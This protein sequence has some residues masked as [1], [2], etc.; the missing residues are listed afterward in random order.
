MQQHC[1]RLG[2]AISLVLAPISLPHASALEPPEKPK[3]VLIVVFDQMRP[4]YAERFDMRNLLSLQKTGVHFPNGYLGHL[5]AQTVVSHNVMV[6]GLYPKRQGWVDEGYRDRLNLLGKGTNAIWE[7]G[8]LTA[9]QFGILIRHAGYPKLVDYLHKARPGSKFIVVGEKSHPVDSIAAPN[10]DISVRHSERSSDTSPATG[11]ANLGGSWRG[12][13]GINV[14]RY[15]S[16]PRCGR[17]YINSDKAND[18]DTRKASPSWLYPLEGNR[19]VAG[20]DPGHLGGDAWSADAAMTMMEREDWGGMLVTLGGI[21]KAGH[22][23][24]AYRDNNSA[25]GSIDE[26]SRVPFAAKFADE[27][28]GRMLRQLERLGQL[29]ETLIVITADHGATSAKHF[30]GSDERGAGYYNWYF[31]T[32]DYDKP[33]AALGPL[34]A[35]GNLQFSVQSTSISA[36]LK[37]DSPLQKKAAARIMRGLPGVAAT[38]WRDG[39]RFQL[40]AAPG[41]GTAAKLGERELRWW[42]QH[43][44]ELLDS[45]AADSGPDVIGLLAEDVSYGA[46]G[47]H[48]SAK[49]SDQ[50]IPMVIWARNIQPGKPD[51]GF[52]SIDILPTVLDAMGIPQTYPGDGKAWKLRFRQEPDAPGERLETGKS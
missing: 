37:E 25:P 40:D 43:G 48:G 4:E 28:L 20:N 17:F 49:E 12:P 38:Y 7:T 50:R 34:V 22:M 51:Y 18:H 47:D 46:Y 33:A 14:P 44:Q 26:Q 35:T 39:E 13:F 27:Q 19:S 24:G 11:C 2:L 8:S 31:G 42:Q 15:L 30:Y 23:W 10:A 45:M 5:A 3:R 41:Q 36:W 1:K 52:R 29:D 9:E 16:E 6:S 32:T 21:D